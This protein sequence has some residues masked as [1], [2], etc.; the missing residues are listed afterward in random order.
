MNALKLGDR[1]DWVLLLQGLLIANG[2]K[3]KRTGVF[4][5]ATRRAVLNFQRSVGL[6]ADGI[7]GP[8]TAGSLINN[9]IAWGATLSDDAIKA[10]AKK[11]GVSV[12]AIRAINEVE[13]AGSG[14]IAEDTPKILFEGHVFWKRLQAHGLNPEDHVKGNE[15]VL[16]RKWTKRHYVGGIEEYDRLDKAVTIDEQAALESASWGAFQVLG[17][18]WEWLGYASIHDFVEQMARSEDEHLDAAARYLKAAGCVEHIKA[19]DW[20]A[21]ARCY[22][23]P[24]Y[25]KNKYD[26][27]L[28]AA[29]E[30]YARSRKA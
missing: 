26:T 19:K 12:A 3:V 20:A 10:A 24:G 21:V 8:K 27:K 7:V 5:Q 9:P 29:Y 6:I 28:A 15:D 2:A 18:H 14:F 4:D 23:G 25:K 16:Y 13:S 30:K 11:L 17:M 1:G 22:N